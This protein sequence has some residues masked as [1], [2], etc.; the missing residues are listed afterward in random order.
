MA[1]V[2]SISMGKAAR[3]VTMTL[4]V[5]HVKRT[6]ARLWAF[7]ALLRVACFINPCAVVVEDDS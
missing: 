6:R 5:K 4:K 7:T 3:N 2:S 1:T